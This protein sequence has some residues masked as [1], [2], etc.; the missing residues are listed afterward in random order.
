MAEAI[1]VQELTTIGAASGPVDLTLYSFPTRRE[2]IKAANL[3]NAADPV[4]TISAQTAVVAAKA[5]VT[6]KTANRV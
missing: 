4:T 5:A 1:V 2:M 6:H 3:V